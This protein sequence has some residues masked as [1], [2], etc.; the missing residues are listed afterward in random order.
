MTDR[1]PTDDIITTTEGTAIFLLEQTDIT[2]Y[3]VVFLS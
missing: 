2:S 3:F 1:E